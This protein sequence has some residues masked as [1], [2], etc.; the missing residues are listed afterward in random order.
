LLAVC[1]PH[2]RPLFFLIDPSP[3]L[4]LSTNYFLVSEIGVKRVGTRPSK[5]TRIEN[6]HLLLQK[7]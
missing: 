5:A 7:I 2:Q 1:R 4:L 6:E 3:L